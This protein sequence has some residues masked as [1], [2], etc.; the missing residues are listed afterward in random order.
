MVRWVTTERGLDAADF[1][2]VVNAAYSDGTARDVTSRATL[3]AAKPGI[4]KLVGRVVKPVG[5]GIAEALV[6]LVAVCAAKLERFAVEKKSF[7]RVESKPAKTKRLGD[8]IHHAAVCFV[9]HTDHRI[10]RQRAMRRRHAFIAIEDLS[11][12]RAAAVI[13]LGI[14]GRK[15][16]QLTGFWWSRR[17][18]RNADLN[19][20]V[21]AGRK[22][23]D[24]ACQ[25]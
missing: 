19:F 13:G 22:Q 11:A 4:V 1:T 2:L 3:S 16:L 8:N 6:I 5:D 18:R 9:R 24:R 7:I 23:N 10:E 25:E 12:R 20:L 14:V 17:R 15:S 21:T